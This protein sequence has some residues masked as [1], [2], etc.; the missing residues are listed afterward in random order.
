MHLGFVHEHARIDRDTYVNVN[1][2][3]IQ[4]HGNSPA[5][6]FGLVNKILLLGKTQ[7]HPVMNIRYHDVM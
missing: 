6:L 1:Y 2:D 7:F 4:E 5:K 3:N